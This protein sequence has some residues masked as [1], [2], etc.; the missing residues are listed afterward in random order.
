MANFKTHLSFGIALGAAS[1]ILS[2][3]FGLVPRDWSFLALLALMA[4]IGSILPDIDS[5]TSLPFHVAFGS[6]SITVAGLALW[7]T[8]AHFSGDYR[9]IIGLPLGAVFCVWV[10]LGNIFKHMTRHRGMVHSIPTMLLAGLLVFYLA[11]RIGY[12]DWQAFLLGLAISAGFLLHLI[13]DEV[14]AAINF[15]G[16]LFVP[17]KELGSALKLKSAST[18]TNMVVYVLLFFLLLQNGETVFRLSGSLVEMLR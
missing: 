10:V 6:L 8:T 12:L 7:F 9:W 5:D 3:T 2:L 15:N 17:N 1:I 11:F 14:Y 13:L 16:T 4:A 18:A